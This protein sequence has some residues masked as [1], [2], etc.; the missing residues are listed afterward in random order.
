MSIEFYDY[1]YQ[2]KEALG[3]CAIAALHEMAGEIVSSAKRNSPVDTGQLKNS[4]SYI[5]DEEKNEVI[6]GSPLENAIW[7]EF[8]TGEYA[9]DDD[10]RKGGWRYKDAK[11]KWHYTYGKQPNRTLFTAFTSNKTM[12]ENIAKNIFKG[13]DSSKEKSGTNKKQN[14]LKGATQYVHTLEKAYR[15]GKNP[16]I[17]LPESPFK[18]PINELN[19]T[20]TAKVINKATKTISKITGV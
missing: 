8:G 13:L 9:I 15:F 18:N 17:S 19:S 3:D 14:F 16:H 5:V 12:V 2:V 7:N 6:I 4:W 20:K 10:G 11:G 1:S